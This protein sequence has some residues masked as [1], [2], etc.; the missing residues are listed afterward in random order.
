M[1][2]AVLNIPVDKI[3]SAVESTNVGLWSFNVDTNESWYS[4]VWKSILGLPEDF[5]NTWETFWERLH[6]DD[7]EIAKQQIEAHI[8][9]SSSFPYECEFRMRHANGTYRTIVSF[10]RFNR[11]NR[12][13]SG[14]HFDVTEQMNHRLFEAVID[15]VPV[16]VFV[17]DDKRRFKY[18][19]EAFRET[20]E[21][22]GG[23]G[24]IIGK[25]DEEILSNIREVGLFRRADLRVLRDNLPVEISKER[26]T[27]PDGTSVVLATKKAPFDDKR[28]HRR[29]ILGVSTDITQLERTQEQVDLL[30][31]KL[32]ASINQ[33]E[34]V[35]SAEACLE[36]AAFQLV[37]LGYTAALLATV[38]RQNDNDQ[39]STQAEWS[40]GLKL[41][42]FEN[43]DEL[44][45]RLRS[46]ECIK[47]QSRNA[48][49][50]KLAYFA[51]PV[52]T[53][54]RLVGAI[55]A[56]AVSG[57][58]LC[59][60]SERLLIGLAAIVGLVIERS[61]TYE[62]IE[63][64]KMRVADQTRL[65]AFS[66]GA[67]T[68]AH[69]LNHAISTFA[70]E[71]NEAEKN[72]RI[73]AN[74]DALEFL[75]KARRMATLC[76]DLTEKKISEAKAIDKEPSDDVNV[77]DFIHETFTLILPKSKYRKCK[78]K[79]SLHDRQ[80]T[81][82]VRQYKL[83]EILNCLLNNAIEMGARNV[84][85]ETSQ[86]ANEIVLRVRDDG[87]GV[88]E[89][90]KKRIFEFG[91]SIGKPKTGHGLGLTLAKNAA[92]SI[93]GALI[94]ECCGRAAQK[95]STVFAIRLPVNLQVE[96]GK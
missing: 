72:E 20:F 16:L 3:I 46:E 43:T 38:E 21:R 91:V 24:D 83:R 68:V 15:K 8:K 57:S 17:K 13:F 70:L 2:F 42:D 52:S 35:S 84:L 54:S 90:E 37:E 95:K 40:C 78:L 36:A 60:E 65:L 58:A 76:T 28:T 89:N 18:V 31:T 19:N 55:I 59:E 81:L 85:F 67:S 30:L 75:A 44:L 48:E 41:T 1:N 63:R 26:L 96:Q 86:E 73:R 4:G 50:A 87:P 74:K 27:L 94:L 62:R 12:E 51:V 80:L 88:P 29:C 47:L 22:F 23:K 11:T 9:S 64:L 14:S 33:I 45:H 56:G 25:K 77:H 93:G 10:G 69:E 39:L 5:P 66:S 92:E 49:L 79:A 61:Q 71:I 34:S 7:K 6:D 82:R 32:I 53:S